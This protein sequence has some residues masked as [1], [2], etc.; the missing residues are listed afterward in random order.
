MFR[1][2]L[3]KE[4][5]EASTARKNKLKAAHV[6]SKK[7]THYQVI[8][9]KNMLSKVAQ[10]RDTSGEKIKEYMWSQFFHDKTQMR[11]HS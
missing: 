4:I 5:V 8:K 3:I 9:R 6:R 11:Y 2:K 1:E 7:A 10:S